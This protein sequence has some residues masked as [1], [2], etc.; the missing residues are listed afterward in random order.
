MS[1]FGGRAKILLKQFFIWEILFVLLAAHVGNSFAGESRGLCPNPKIQYEK[2][3]AEEYWIEFVRE[4]V[5]QGVRG[6]HYFCA[7][8]SIQF[9]HGRET[10]NALVPLDKIENQK[11]KKKGLIKGI[12]YLIEERRVY[13]ENLDEESLMHYELLG[14][15]VL[16]KKQ[17]ARLEKIFGVKKEDQ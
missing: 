13:F 1:R 10:G 11:E 3:S 2:W 7:K 8:Y 16:G 6:K 14:R 12:N 9:E 15:G 5:S 4:N 17:V